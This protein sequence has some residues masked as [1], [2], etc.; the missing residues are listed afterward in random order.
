MTGKDVLLEKYLLEKAATIKIFEYSPLGEELKKETNIAEKQYQKLDNIYE[1][2]IIIKNIT[3]KNY[4]RSS[5]I[6]NS[7][8]IFY[9]Y[10]NNNLNSLSLTSKFRFFTSFYNELNRFYRLIPQKEST[11]QKKTTVYDNGSEM[12]NEYLETY[13]NPLLHNDAIWRHILSLSLAN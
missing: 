5:L 9:E 12:Y 2:D 8:F 3:I 13:F 11:K 7:K 1:F 10:Y 6:Y 4:N